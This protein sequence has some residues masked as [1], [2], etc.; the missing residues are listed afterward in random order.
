M[1]KTHWRSS[2][3]VQIALTEDSHEALVVRS[4]PLQPEQFVRTYVLCL[5]AWLGWSWPESHLNSETNEHAKFVVFSWKLDVGVSAMPWT[6]CE[7]FP[8]V[9][10]SVWCAKLLIAYSDLKSWEIHVGKRNCE[11]KESSADYFSAS[12]DSQPRKK[13][14]IFIVVKVNAI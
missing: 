11:T 8:P 14:S 3:P 12:Q 4:N 2:W 6:E 7:I 5:L 10:L 1:T 9:F 13:K